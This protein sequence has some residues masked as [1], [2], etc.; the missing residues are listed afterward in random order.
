MENTS[1]NYIWIISGALSEEKPIPLRPL[2]FL[3]SVVVQKLLNQIHVCHQH[4][5]TAITDQTQSIQSITAKQNVQIN[6]CMPVPPNADKLIK[7]LKTDLHVFLPAFK[8][9]SQNV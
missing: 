7:A 1:I 3:Q 8:K 6:F 5:A 2:R 9:F 4:S